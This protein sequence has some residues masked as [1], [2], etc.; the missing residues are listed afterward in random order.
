MAAAYV[1]S[2]ERS[3]LTWPHL[4][5]PLCVSEIVGLSPLVEDREG[6]GDVSPH[7]TL[8][9][10]Y[11]LPHTFSGILEDTSFERHTFFLFIPTL[12]ASDRMTSRA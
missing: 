4:S 10:L 5:G 1:C 11:N 8:F 7:S 6:G 3:H 9:F 2:Y 12:I